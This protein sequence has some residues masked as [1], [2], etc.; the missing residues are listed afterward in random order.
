MNPGAWVRAPPAALH[1][2]RRSPKLKSGRAPG[3]RPRSLVRGPAAGRCGMV[4]EAPEAA[5]SNPA[6]LPSRGASTWKPVAQRLEL[7]KRV[8]DQ[9]V[10]VTA[11]AG[12]GWFSFNPAVAGSTPAGLPDAPH[13]TRPLR[14]ADGAGWDCSS[15]AERASPR[16][17]RPRAGRRTRLIDRRSKG[18]GFES[19]QS[20]CR[21]W[22]PHR[23][24]GRARSVIAP[25]PDTRPGADADHRPR[26][27]AAKDG[28]QGRRRSD[29]SPQLVHRQRWADGRGLP[30]SS[31]FEPRPPPVL[32][33]GSLTEMGSRVEAVRLSL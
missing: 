21:R 1:A 8:P 14:A 32:L 3:V 18:R 30:G 20:H 23:R 26:G 28:E 29:A 31:V 10:R 9:L 24:A 7:R 4:T 11:R 6:G 19:R 2:A 13:I 17:A 15:A 22:E 5:G 12:V 16:L 25:H 27:G 33:D